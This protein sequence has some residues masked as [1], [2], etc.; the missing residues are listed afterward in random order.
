MPLLLDGVRADFLREPDGSGAAQDW[1]EGPGLLLLWDRAGVT[2]YRVLS[3]EGALAPRVPVL[4]ILLLYALGFAMRK[5]VQ[6][7]FLEAEL[8]EL[9]LL[10]SKLLGGYLYVLFDDRV[11]GGRRLVVSP[12]VASLG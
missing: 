3:L 7:V 1:V 12:R 6:P 4:A 2:K 9:P 8:A 5:L 11:R 10:N